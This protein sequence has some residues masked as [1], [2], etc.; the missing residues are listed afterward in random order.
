MILGKDVEKAFKGPQD[1]EW[2]IEQE[3][4]IFLL[5]TRPL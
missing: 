3:G 1:I 5:Q 4:D 2:A